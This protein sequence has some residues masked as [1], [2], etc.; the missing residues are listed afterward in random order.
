ME[1]GMSMDTKELGR[2]GVGFREE[3]KRMNLGSQKK[4]SD[5]IQTMKNGEEKRCKG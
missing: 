2:G 4:G 1:H 5:M 3:S